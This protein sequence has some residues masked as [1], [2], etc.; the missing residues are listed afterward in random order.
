MWY[1]AFIIIG[2]RSR[3]RGDS[4]TM[5]IDQPDCQ[6]RGGCHH[7]SESRKSEHTDKLQL[8]ISGCT[9]I[10]PDPAQAGKASAVSRR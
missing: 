2:L 1:I 8:R 7:L 3:T 10:V 5:T 4:A 6:S 9:F